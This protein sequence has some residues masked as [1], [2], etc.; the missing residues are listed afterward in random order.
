[1]ANMVADVLS[2]NPLGEADAEDDTG[3]N[4]IKFALEIMS[5][6]VTPL[7]Y[8]KDLHNVIRFLQEFEY[9]EHADETLWRQIWQHSCY[10]PNT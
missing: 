9:L 5:M 8:E 7:E 10:E 4:S 2:R 1:M 3:Q 6:E